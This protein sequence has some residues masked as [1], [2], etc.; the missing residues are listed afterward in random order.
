MLSFAQLLTPVPL[1]DW[2][3]KIIEV[4]SAVGLQTQNWSE[5]GYTRTLVALFA[6]LYTTA[7]DVIRIIAAGGFLD[8]AEGDW[9][10]WLA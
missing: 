1:E 6:Q 3:R 2:K 9:L 10:T 5:G 7:G 4:A 8:T